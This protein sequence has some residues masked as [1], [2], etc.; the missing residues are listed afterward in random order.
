[1]LLLVVLQSSTLRAISAWYVGHSVVYEQDTIMH[2]GDNV[3]LF[4]S[5]VLWVWAKQSASPDIKSYELHYG[6]KHP[7]AAFDREAMISKAEAL[8]DAQ[9]DQTATGSHHKKK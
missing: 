1:M 6:S 3:T 8:R 2:G 5:C 4:L 7:K 9:Q